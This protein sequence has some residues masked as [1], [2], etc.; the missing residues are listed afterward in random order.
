MTTSLAPARQHVDHCSLYRA[1]RCVPA[2]AT[3][4]LAAKLRGHTQC[5]RGHD[6][7]G[8]LGPHQTDSSPH[9]LTLG[10]ETT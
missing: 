8:P 4:V 3:S 2:L 6:V 7:L 5:R 9:A 1:P 10:S